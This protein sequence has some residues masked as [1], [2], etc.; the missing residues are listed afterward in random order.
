[1]AF[2]KG[3]WF[4]KGMQKTLHGTKKWEEGVC[5]LAGVDLQAMLSALM[6]S[7]YDKD[8]NYLYIGLADRCVIPQYYL[9]SPF[10]LLCCQVF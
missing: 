4:W 6:Y 3:K 10:C 5:L 9:A 7:W 1:M 8:L 2:C